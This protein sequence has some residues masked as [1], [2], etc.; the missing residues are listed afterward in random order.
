VRSNTFVTHVAETDP[1]RKP[2]IQ[3]MQRRQKKSRE[4]EKKKTAEKHLQRINRMRHLYGLPNTS[5]SP[6]TP[7]SSRVPVPPPLTP[8]VYL[9]PV[10]SPSTLTRTKALAPA[11][12]DSRSRGVFS[13]SSPSRSNY[14]LPV[15]Q[16][17]LHGST[18]FSTT[19]LDPD[20]SSNLNKQRGSASS[21]SPHAFL[22]GTPAAVPRAV[23][24]FSIQ[25]NEEGHQQLKHS[26]SSR[27]LKRMSRPG[28]VSPL[29]I[30][31]AAGA[32][33]DWEAEVDD[34]LQWSTQIDSPRGEALL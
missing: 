34:L 7:P 20:M 10:T 24:S 12:V 5:T 29:A 13:P 27:P 6:S 32:S 3:N 11:R 28:T 1:M 15:T 16:P 26:P 2:V 19:P 31:P 17:K 21:N 8:K 33:E 9:R 22:P 18:D 25:S 30:K 4:R 23:P 14:T